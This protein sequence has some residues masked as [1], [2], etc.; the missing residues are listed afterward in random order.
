MY[1][2]SFR[3]KDVKDAFL[4][5]KLVVL[6]EMASGGHKKLYL[7][8]F[9]ELVLRVSVLRYPPRPAT[10]PEVAKSLQKLF[11][12]HF[13]K[14]EALI[15]Q[16]CTT[17]DQA[18]VQDRIEAFAS[19]LTSHRKRDEDAEIGGGGGGSTSR[20]GSITSRR[21]SLI[22]AD[23]PPAAQDRDE[24]QQAQSA[25]SSALLDPLQATQPTEAESQPPEKASDTT[26][27]PPSGVEQV[28]L[29]ADEAVQVSVPVVSHLEAEPATIPTST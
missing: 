24:G 2:D 6:D 29:L 5:C 16:F 28:S 20:R 3:A 27:E 21:P 26:T 19:A 13:Y 14:H 9:M 18:L 17:V 7:T 11:Q 8:D 25:E 4:A 1:S 23:Q 15:D 10:L 12:N 22:S